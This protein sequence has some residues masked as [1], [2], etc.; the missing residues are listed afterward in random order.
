MNANV[1]ESWLHDATAVKLILIPGNISYRC[2]RGGNRTQ[3]DI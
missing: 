3:S 2:H 1:V